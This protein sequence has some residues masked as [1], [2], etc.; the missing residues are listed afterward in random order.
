MNLSYFTFPPIRKEKLELLFHLIVGHENEISLFPIGDIWKLPKGIVL[1]CLG[2]YQDTIDWI[3]D[4]EQKFI[5]HS[6]EGCK[7]AGK[8]YL[9]SCKIP[10]L[11]SLPSSHCVLTCWK[12]ARELSRPLS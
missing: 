4:K 11:S 8:I 9:V 12:R 2:C 6:S 10:L 5:S 1:F 7:E 3:A